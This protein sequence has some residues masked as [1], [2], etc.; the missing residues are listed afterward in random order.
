MRDRMEAAATVNAHVAMTSRVEE[1]RD[2]SLW[3]S[4]N[5][6]GEDPRP[7]APS[8]SLHIRSNAVGRKARGQTPT[9]SSYCLPR[10]RQTRHSVV[11]RTGAATGDMVAD[12]A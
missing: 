5:T 2:S 6:A 8:L 10:R 11:P 9:R 1:R 7:I 4:S 3:K 12:K